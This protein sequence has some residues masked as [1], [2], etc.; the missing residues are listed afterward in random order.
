[1]TGF[2]LLT[3]PVGS[4][5]STN[6]A[7]TAALSVSVFVS[8]FKPNVLWF[9]LLIRWVINGAA[10]EAISIVTPAMEKCGT[11]PL[12]WLLWALVTP[13]KAIRVRVGVIEMWELNRVKHRSL[14]KKGWWDPNR[15]V[16]WHWLLVSFGYL[17]LTLS[18]DLALQTVCLSFGFVTSSVCPLGFAVCLF[19][20]HVLSTN[21][22]P[23]STSTI[24]IAFI[25]IILI[26]YFFNDYDDVNSDESFNKPSNEIGFQS[27][28][29]NFDSIL[30]L[31]GPLPTSFQFILI[32]VK[33]F[34]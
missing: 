29:N 10:W 19:V 25:T 6:W 9:G 20:Y 18:F 15:K 16:L 32:L 14:E 11:L 5:R 28:G 7:T 13:V 30:P 21:Q 26:S 33:H 12:A 23:I 31:N 8:I 17:S 4:D 2:E 24:K 27:R 1:M 3:S 22:P 34:L